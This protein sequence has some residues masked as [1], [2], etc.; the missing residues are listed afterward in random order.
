MMRLMTLLQNRRVPLSAR[1]R[2][3]ISRP[4]NPGSGLN[5]LLLQVEPRNALTTGLFL[6]T[7]HV[8]FITQDFC[9]ECSSG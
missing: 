4:P 6:E 8:H 1:T 9:V 3:F 5:P 2:H 7:R